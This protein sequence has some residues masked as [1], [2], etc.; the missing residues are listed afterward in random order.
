MADLLIND[1]YITFVDYYGNED[2]RDNTWLCRARQLPRP[3]PLSEDEYVEYNAGSLGYIERWPHV[4]QRE[5]FKFE[6]LAVS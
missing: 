2:F 4:G 6:W 5:S 3:E 1:R